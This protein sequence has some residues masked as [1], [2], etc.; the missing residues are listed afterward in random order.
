MNEEELI[1][2]IN[3]LV[4]Q[5]R[6]L[7]KRLENTVNA[8]KFYDSAL[9]TDAVAS[10]HGVSP[11]VVRKYMKLGLIEPHPMS[12]EGKL[13]IRGSVALLLDFCQLKKKAKFL[14]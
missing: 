8:D 2:S 3:E 11:S 9:N 5:K 6:L 14:R 4:S 10:L 7:E 13:L 1:L 12:S